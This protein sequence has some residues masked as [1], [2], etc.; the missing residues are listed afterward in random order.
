MEPSNFIFWAVI[1]VMLAGLL[2]ILLTFIYVFTKRK[3]Q[4]SLLRS[5]TFI[6]WSGLAG[7]FGG[8]LFIVFEHLY[9]FT[10]GT[11]Q[12]PRNA[13]VFGMT[14]THYYQLSI[15]WQLLIVFALV[16]LYARYGMRA[17]RLGGG[18]SV[19]AVLGMVMLVISTVLQVYI[20]D[21]NKH[22]YSLPVQSGWMLQLLSYPVYSIGMVLLGIATF[23]S[24]VMPRWSGLM[25]I[26]GLLPLLSLMFRS[27]LI[28]LLSLVI[29]P[30]VG[31]VFGSDLTRD[32]LAAAPSVPYG[33]SWMLLGC[34]IARAKMPTF[35][36]PLPSSNAN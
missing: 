14:N 5:P 16:G 34:V 19:M 24:R 15:S 27:Y 23:R 31:A 33:L 3:G 36:E 28:A 2:A 25:L 6:R 7:V 22:F 26:I 30:I 32:I 9:F 8:L 20:V 12:V 17:G 29:T 1:A 10:H 11:S 35:D 4:P 18:G 13:T 21:P